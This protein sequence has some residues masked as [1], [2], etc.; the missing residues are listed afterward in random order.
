MFLQ[1]P[2]GPSVSTGVLGERQ[3]GESKRD[4]LALRAMKIEVGHETRNVGNL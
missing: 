1:Y 3:T 4:L 2:G